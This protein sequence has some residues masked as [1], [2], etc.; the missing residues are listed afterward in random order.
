MK[1]THENY[2]KLPWKK[3][4]EPAIKLASEGFAVNERLYLLANKISYLKD[5]NESSQIYL[6]KNGKAFAVGTIIKNA[7]IAKTLNTIANDGIKPFYEGYIAKDMVNA[8]NNS[9]TNAGLLSLSDLKNYKSKKGDL[10]CATYRV[11]YKVCSM[12]LPSSGGISVLQILGILENFDLKKSGYNS[13]KT[14][15][16]ILEATKLAYADRNEYVADTN[17]VP[18]AQMLD[19]KYLAS[20]AKLIDFN[21]A[22]KNA[23]AGKFANAKTLE[24]QGF[25]KVDNFEHPSTTHI[26]VVDEEGNAVALTSSIEYFFGSGLSVDGFML[27]NQMTD[28]SLTPEINGKKIANRVQPLK[29]PRSSMSPTFV[30]DEN[31]NLIMVVGSPGGPR[32]IQFTV[33]TIINHLDF[34]KDIQAA[35]SSPNFVVLNDVVELEEKTSITKLKKSLEKIGH[36]IKTIEITS[37]INAIAIENNNLTAGA[38]P[39]RQGFAVG[40]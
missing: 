19:K 38:D 1:E 23:Q 14:I 21:K 20:R 32:I 22:M 12:P 18:V 26:S 30:F 24:M 35:I 39:R 6:D 37:G 13:S 29:Q 11:K 28:F 10:I 4:F 36:T 16:T 34:N 33:K 3:L 9:K 17:D 15:H 27:N 40:E 8:I 5:F 31:N 25:A 2:G 7:P